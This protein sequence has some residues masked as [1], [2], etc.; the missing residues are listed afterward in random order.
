[1]RDLN[2]NNKNTTINVTIKNRKKGMRL[3][4]SEELLMYHSIIR[5]DL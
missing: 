5:G 2:T 4:H 3:N 1:M